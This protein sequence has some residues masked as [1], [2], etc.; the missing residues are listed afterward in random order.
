MSTTPIDFSKYEQAAAPSID[1]SKYAAPAS[2]QP[3]VMSNL[4]LTEG[5]DVQITDYPHATLSGVQSIGRGLKGAAASTLQL[6]DP[7]PKDSQEDT[8]SALGPEVLPVYRLLRSLGHSAEDATQ[9]SGAVHDINNSPDPTGTYMKAAQETAGQGAG[10]ALAALGTEG[11]A[12]AAPAV[13]DAAKATPAAIS[14]VLNHP[15]MKALGKTTDALTFDRLGKIVDAWRKVPEELRARSANTP[16]PPEVLHDQPS[17]T[18]EQLNPSLVSPARTLPG[19][20][21]PEVIAPAPQGT[22]AQIPPRSGLQLPPAPVYPG[23]PLPE[24]I[25]PEV[26]QAKGL[27]EGAKAVPDPAAVLAKIPSRAVQQAVS[28]LGPKAPLADIAGRSQQIMEL[29]NKGLGGKALEPNVPL[30]NQG[31]IITPKPIEGTIPEGHTPVESSALKSYKYDPATQEFE[32]VTRGGQHY[33]HGD[34]SPEQ[35]A[36]FEAAASKGKAWAD[37]RNNSTLVAK[38]INGKRVPI[39]PVVSDED[40]ISPDEWEAGHELETQV[41]GSPR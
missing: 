31:G 2:P 13:V 29:L 38:V 40:L 35:A 34:V 6:F 17:A 4:G 22:A 28:E 14:E 18:P 12:K 39:R 25:G 37:L 7:R 33:I 20:I 41:E 10:Q 9:L 26:T 15:V 8:V 23:A 30:K 16:V 21:S 5:P 32:S 19:Q 36:A 24:A 1:F 11:L 27:A 3:T